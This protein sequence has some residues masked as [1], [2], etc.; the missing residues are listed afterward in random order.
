MASRTRTWL[1][2]ILC[3]AFILNGLPSSAPIVSASSR[4]SQPALGLSDHSPQKAYSVQGNEAVARPETALAV[5]QPITDSHASASALIA[6]T[7]SG[8]EPAAI[9]VE[10]GTEVVWK[11]ETAQTHVLKSGEPYA[12]YL[13]LILRQTPGAGRLSASAQLPRI[14]PLRTASD[15]FMATI[16][17][18]GT[19]SHTFITKGEYPYYLVTDLK[20][21]G[22][23]T[24]TGSIPPDPGTVAPPVDP[25]VPTTVISSTL[26]LYTG[27]DPIQTGV[28]PGQSKHGGWP[29]CAAGC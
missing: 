21:R 4:A 9:T 23:V 22:R 26:F 3:F 7:A 1:S 12:I 6:I 19:F 11:N 27:P 20:Q 17:P 16:S 18:G 2:V 25:T 15:D 28:A 13:P 8:F 24:V 10:A 29:S 5:R 14:T